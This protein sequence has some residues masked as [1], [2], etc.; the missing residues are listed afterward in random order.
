MH[1]V[2]L[3]VFAPSFEK[4]FSFGFLMH[5]VEL[6][7]T[8]RFTK[9]ELVKLFLMHRVE[10]KVS[11]NKLIFS[12]FNKF[13]MHR[14]ELKAFAKQLGVTK[15]TFIVNVPNAPCGVERF[16]CQIISSLFVFCS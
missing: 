13:L 1:R 15:K 4:C 2:E 3:K 16:F 12:V 8:I 10:L 9:T 5:R 6:K 7:A 11:T 14:V